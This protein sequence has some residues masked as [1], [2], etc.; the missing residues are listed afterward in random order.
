MPWWETRA[1]S[2]P[3]YSGPVGFKRPIRHLVK[4]SGVRGKAASRLLQPLP[5]VLEDQLGKLENQLRLSVNSKIDTN[6]VRGRRKSDSQRSKNSEGPLLDEQSDSSEDSDD[7]S[8]PIHDLVD[9]TDAPLMRRQIV[10]HYRGDIVDKENLVLQN[11]M[12]ARES[13]ALTELYKSS[14]V[15]YLKIQDSVLKTHDE[16]ELHK[17]T[18]SLLWKIGMQPFENLKEKIRNYNNKWVDALELTHSSQ[19]MPNLNPPIPAAARNLLEEF[20]RCCKSPNSAE[21]RMLV[22]VTKVSSADDIEMW[23]GM[24]RHQDRHKFK[25]RKKNTSEVDYVASE[26]SEDSDWFSTTSSGEDS[27]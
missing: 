7:D 15:S 14:L 5:E 4:R 8:D 19:E 9:A 3:K 1:G 25:S 23:F 27:S 6:T 12:Y 22:Q 17:S 26:P 21:I 20:Y 10:L 11:E 24:R 13:D 2:A 18:F 16:L